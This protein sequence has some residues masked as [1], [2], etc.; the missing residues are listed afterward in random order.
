MFWTLIASRKRIEKLNFSIRWLSNVKN[1][2]LSNG[3]EQ[4]RNV[5]KIAFFFQKL[6][7]IVQLLEALPRIPIATGG[8]GLRPQD[9]R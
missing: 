5:I 8:L 6:T 7:K 3:C 1:R 4:V 9:P 2:V